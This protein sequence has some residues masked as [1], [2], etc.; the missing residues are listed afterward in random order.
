MTSIS[1]DFASIP[2]GTAGT[3][4]AEPAG[5]LLGLLTYAILAVA[6]SSA[7]AAAY[8]WYVGDVLPEG[9]AVLFGVSIVALYL[10]TASL[11]SYVSG[12]R[13]GLFDPETAIFNV[14]ALGVATAVSPVGL[15]FGDALAGAGTAM[16]GGRRLGG[17]I[18]EVVRSVGR[19]TPVTLPPAEE[20]RDIDSYDPVAPGTK[21]RMGG[22]TLR[23]PRQITV[24]ELRG[25]LVSRLKTDYGV[26]HVDLE[27]SADGTVSYLGVGSRAAGIGP[28][29]APGSVALAVRAD[30]P[31]A[32]TPGD[33][34]QVWTDGETPERVATGE[35]RA[36]AGD[37]VTLAL[38]EPD[39]EQIADVERYR[40]LTL[41]AEPQ[42]D[43]EFASLLRNADEMV[44][45]MTVPEGGVTAGSRIDTFE[46]MVAAVQPTDGPVLAIPPKNYT[47]SVGDTL[48]VIGSP[49][50]VR[51]TER[52]VRG[53]ESAEPRTQSS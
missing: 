50:T 11:G 28:T 47:L 43:R 53:E 52:R 29:L 4:F 42:G 38:E 16:T 46:A 31:H 1:M 20:I 51:R 2:S 32:A 3:T 23:F 34:V 40:V 48:Y 9:I 41:P 13:V 36:S 45:A 27:V 6:V 21:E 30:P 22:E 39:A 18:S 33:L 24:E 14:V 5:A 25:R 8:R 17:D 12:S 10:N 49:E 26:G 44:S 19:V 7:A 35:L 15:R 37:V